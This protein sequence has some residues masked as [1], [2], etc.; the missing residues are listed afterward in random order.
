MSQGPPLALPF[1]ERFTCLDTPL[2]IEI[3]VFALVNQNEYTV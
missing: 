3:Y 1:L 2:E